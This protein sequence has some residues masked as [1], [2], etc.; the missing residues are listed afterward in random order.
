MPNQPF[1][2][3]T[4]QQVGAAG[5]YAASPAVVAAIRTAA[6]HTG[7]RF[8]SLLASAAIESGFNPSAK[9]SSSSA[10][11]LFQF[12]DQTWLATLKKSGADNGLAAQAAAIVN[13]GG[14][15]T[16]EDPEMRHEIMEL[17]K[18]PQ[19]AA[20]MAGEHM[21]D[22]TANLASSLGHTPDVTETYLGHFLGAKGATQ[23]LNALKNDPMRSAASVLPEAAHANPALFDG[24]SVAQFV[25]KIQGR[26]EK[27]YADLGMS[28]PQGALQIS[29]AS[30]LSVTATADGSDGWGKGTPTKLSTAPE[31]MMLASLTNV[32]TRMDKLMNSKNDNNND[33][34]NRKNASSTQLPLGVLSALEHGTSVETANQASGET[35]L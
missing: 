25:S 26:I 4:L 8:E 17:R 20:T 9:A 18:N 16:V 12:V 29:S 2:Q 1:S 14:Q 5:R 6:T 23:I 35:N 22:L 10:T 33:N 3:H 30:H 11:G 27:T 15:W 31:R 34:D 7:A 24:K 32:F 13:R 19:V 21:K 28:V